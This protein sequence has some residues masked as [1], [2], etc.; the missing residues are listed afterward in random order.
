MTSNEMLSQLSQD[1]P[2]AI[3]ARN[4]TTRKWRVKIERPEGSEPLP[5]G[6]RGSVLITMRGGQY[7]TAT[8]E[9][10]SSLVHTTP[11]KIGESNRFQ[12]A[13]IIEQSNKGQGRINHFAEMRIDI[14]N[15]TPAAYY[16]AN[17]SHNLT[18]TKLRDCLLYTSPSP[19]DS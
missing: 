6:S 15:D 16:R 7:S 19:R 9:T 2:T 5:V 13:T 4:P 14:A 17:S 3:F 11:H 1:L 12:Y 8:V 10:T 18:I